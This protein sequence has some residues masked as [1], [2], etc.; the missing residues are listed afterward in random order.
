MVLAKAGKGPFSGW[1]A[2]MEV[3]ISDGTRLISDQGPLCLIAGYRASLH[4]NYLYRWST[5]V[6]CCND[7]CSDA[8]FSTSRQ[9]TATG[10]DT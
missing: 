2:G 4:V 5:D 3:A 10:P 7:I 6:H 8:T 1:R 9:E